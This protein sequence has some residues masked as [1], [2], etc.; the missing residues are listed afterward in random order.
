MTSLIYTGEEDVYTVR[1]DEQSAFISLAAS[2][3]RK[4]ANAV[5]AE[6]AA[7]REEQQTIRE[8]IATLEGK[9]RYMDREVFEADLDRAAKGF[10]AKL[11]TPIKKAIFAALGERDPKAEICRDSKGKSEP[12]SELRDTENIPLRGYPALPEAFLEKISKVENIAHRGAKLPMFFGPDMPNEDLV[13]AMTPA[14]DAY[15]WKYFPA[16]RGFGV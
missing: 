15:I 9:G 7:G 8:I 14:I 11:S 2:R 6:E 4:D 3:K 13:E 12:D 10:G 16:G 5:E 1:L